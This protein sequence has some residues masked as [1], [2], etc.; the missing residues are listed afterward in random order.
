M[1]FPGAVETEPL[2]HKMAAIGIVEIDNLGQKIDLACRPSPLSA[3]FATLRRCGFVDPAG[4]VHPPTPLL[5]RCCH[6][7]P[8]GIFCA[9]N[10][11][12]YSLRRYPA[13]EPPPLPYP[14][15]MVPG[16][17]LHPMPRIPS[18]EA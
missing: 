3:G 17:I 2:P 11:I 6:P 13:R 5:T 12:N 4:W 8:V 7:A 16:A 9:C 18:R 15:P 1:G 10:K 14:E